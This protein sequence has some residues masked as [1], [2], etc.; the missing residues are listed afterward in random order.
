MALAPDVAELEVGVVVAGV[1][2]VDDEDRLAVVD[3]VGGEEVVVARAGRHGPNAH[4]LADAPDG[5]G[6]V[7]VAPREAKAA[8]LDP[9]QV[10]GLAFEHVEA[11]DEGLA[12]VETPAGQRHPGQDPGLLQ[13]IVG[14]R[15][16]LEEAEHEDPVVGEEVDD[17]RTHAGGRGADA[18]LVL[19]PAVD[20]QLVGRRRGRM[21]EDIGP[22]GCRDLVV[23][24]GETPGEAARPGGTDRGRPRSAP[25]GRGRGQRR[26]RRSPRQMVGSAQG[27]EEAGKS[28]PPSCSRISS[29]IVLLGPVNQFFTETCQ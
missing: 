10:V 25:G 20:G 6:V 29:S 3:E 1:L 9:A 23:L 16:A 22:V 5:L 14:E 13:V 24:V 4:G 21:A 27:S 17:G 2:V 11:V 26:R 18:V 19:G 28:T 12:G 8:P 7:E 15:R